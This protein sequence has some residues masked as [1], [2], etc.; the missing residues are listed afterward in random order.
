MN[1][2]LIILAIAVVVVVI[3]LVV[4]KSDLAS[5]VRAWFTSGQ[6]NA[7]GA[8]DSV[9]ARTDAAQVAQDTTVRKG[10][11]TLYSLKIMLAESQTEIEKVDGEIADDQ[12]AMAMAHKNGDKDTFVT[13]V[14]E[15]NRDTAYR[16]QLVPA[17][18]Q[19]VNQLKTL[20][21]GVDEQA[22]KA[23]EIAIQSRVMVAQ[24]RVNDLTAGVNEALAGLNGNSADS[25]M[26]AARKILDKTH[27]RAVASADAAEG[28]TPNERSQ[29]KAQAYIKQA[30]T[31]ADSI[32]ANTLWD[33]MSAGDTP[34]K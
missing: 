11:T 6:K 15:L 14:N 10:R 8:V 5:A 27:A 3:Y 26:E 12:N 24:A 34:A 29:K 20:E 32:D 31:G 22:D 33:K 2:F 21:V 18:E 7:A 19:L 1:T 17:H 30:K 16:N 4:S 9:K 13:L 25:H 23:R 28:L